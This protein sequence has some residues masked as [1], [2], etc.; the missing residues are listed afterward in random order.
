MMKTL[1]QVLSEIPL[2]T[3]IKIGSKVSF[4]YCYYNNENTINKLK[5]ESNRYYQ[6]LQ[7]QLLRRTVE[8]EGLDKRLANGYR[9][10]ETTKKI[11]AKTIAK[12]KAELLAKVEKDRVILPRCIEKIKKRINE[13]TPLLDRPVVR[14]Y[15]LNMPEYENPK[16]VYIFVKGNEVGDYCDLQEYATAKH[17][18]INKC[19][20]LWKDKLANRKSTKKKAE[21]KPK[22]TKSVKLAN[23]KKVRFEQY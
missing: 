13:F 1:K 5:S 15:N 7:K 2:G 9:K 4:F 17:L 23:G 22:F 11:T 10:I 3:P 6:S 12:K 19:D 14:Q 20:D 18:P 16:T 21:P 8:Y